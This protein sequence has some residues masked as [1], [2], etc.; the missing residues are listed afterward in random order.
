MLGAQSRPAR[1]SDDLL[2]LIAAYKL[3]RP[4]RLIFN[5]FQI[6]SEDGLYKDLLLFLSHHFHQAAILIMKA[7]SHRTFEF[8]DVQ[9]L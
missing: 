4:V 8:D 3:F 5:W 9:R 7:N 1:I 2:N 6:Q